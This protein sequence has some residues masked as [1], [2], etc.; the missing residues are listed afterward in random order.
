M[1][2]RDILSQASRRVGYDTWASVP[3]EDL[4]HALRFAEED[5]LQDTQVA[6]QTKFI[7][8]AENLFN[9]NLPVN[10]GE[11]HEYAVFNNEGAKLAH[12]ELTYEEF[13]GWNPGIIDSKTENEML[14]SGYSTPDDGRDRARLHGMIVTAIRHDTNVGRYK[15]Y[16]KPSV[17]GKVEIY[18]SPAL[19]E[20]IFDD[21]ELE[22]RI[23]ERFHR[24]IVF[25]VAM[26]LAEVEEGRALGNGNN[27][28][29]QSYRILKN[30]L[31][32]AFGERES[33]IK[34]QSVTRTESQIIK[35]FMWYD[36]PKKY[37]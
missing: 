12:K 16:M 29:A 26:Y 33:K 22:S 5:I 36:S 23:P 2:Y 9:Y 25:G 32:A 28:R 15:L 27:E 18:Y 31:R 37:R 10:F 4:L 1:L 24:Y 20:N 14:P 3:K 21:L 13:M 35:P 19:P 7:F 11:P 6:K 8:T 34:A 17:Q 30:T